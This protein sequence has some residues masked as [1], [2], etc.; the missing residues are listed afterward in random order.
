MDTL[1][2]V[3]QIEKVERAV[4]T[5]SRDDREIKSVTLT[6]RYP[7]TLA[8]LWDACTDGERISRWLMPITG[9]L[10]VGGRYQLHGNAGGVIEQCVPHERIA[11]TWEFGGD[12]SW[13]VA[14]FSATSGGAQV[15]VEHIAYVDQERWEQFGPGAVGIGWDSML[16][17]LALHLG[18]GVALDPE[19]AMAWMTSPEGMEFM[20]RS[21]EAWRVA[22]IASGD[23]P[24]AATA[25]AERCLAAY[26]GG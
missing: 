14:T 4:T 19:Q 13:V 12:V 9:E 8:D 21:G 5:G 17:G 23:D 16:L 2:A 20:R 7:V 15:H 6:E 1:N 22:H 11:V 25:A 18:S 10:H 3:D 24:E 26:T